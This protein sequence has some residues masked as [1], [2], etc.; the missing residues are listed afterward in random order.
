MVVTSDT[1]VVVD[2]YKALIEKFKDT[3]SLRYDVQIH[4]LFS[5]HIK[6]EEQHTNLT[7]THKNKKKQVLNVYLGTPNRL[8]KLAL[9]ETYTM[10][11]SSGSFR[12]MVVDCRVNKKGFTIFEVK[13]TRADSLD[14][15]VLGEEAWMRKEKEGMI[16]LV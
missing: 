14:L 15:L 10:G 13:E 12:Y 4:K 2:L 7:Q 9:K 6:V 1:Y 3:R 8:K 16:V 5:K 11:D